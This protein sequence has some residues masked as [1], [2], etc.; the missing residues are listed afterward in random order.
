M[1]LAFDPAQ[2]RRRRHPHGL[3]GILR[4]QFVAAA[5]HQHEAKEPRVVTI[6]QLPKGRFVS[7]RDRRRQGASLG[8]GAGQGGLQ[9]GGLGGLWRGFRPEPGCEVGADGHSFIVRTHLGAANPPG[10]IAS[11]F[12]RLSDG[13]GCEFRPSSA[14]ARKA[15]SAC[16]MNTIWSWEPLATTNCASLW[17]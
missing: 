4:E 13:F 14:L 3:D 8:I 5:Q 11:A 10:F 9:A 15:E 1:W 7:A 16:S 2:L 17:N 12:G 6:I